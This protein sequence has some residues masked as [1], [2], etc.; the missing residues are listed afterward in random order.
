MPEKQ[1]FIA[2]QLKVVD[3]LKTEM[4][5]ALAS[6]F[7]GLH[8]ADDEAIVENMAAMVL[9]HYALAR[10]LGIP[11]YRLEE[12]MLEQIR[13]QKQLGHPLEEWYQDWSVL[14]EYLAAGRIGE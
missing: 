11:F 6:L 3:G 2:K 13:R 5:E 10:R 4:A 9:L 1:V 8:E 7:R 12:K 14:E